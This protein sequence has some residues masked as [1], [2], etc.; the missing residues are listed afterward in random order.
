VSFGEW[1][2]NRGAHLTVT[3]K[4]CDLVVT[5]YLRFVIKAFLSKNLQK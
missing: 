2:N 5:G 1:W 3:P 4:L